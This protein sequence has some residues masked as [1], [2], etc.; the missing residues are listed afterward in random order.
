[1]Q[2]TPTEKLTMIVKALALILEEFDDTGYS[3]F[4]IKKNIY[5]SKF[6]HNFSL[7]ESSF[8]CSGLWTSGLVRRLL[9]YGIYL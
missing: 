8:S 4:Y 5:P 9:R 2:E 3:E 1:V 7:S 6:F